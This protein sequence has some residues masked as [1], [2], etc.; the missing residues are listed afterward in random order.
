M[1]KC[2]INECLHPLNFFPFVFFV[3]PKYYNISI[4]NIADH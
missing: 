1:Q 4:S 2:A 3:S